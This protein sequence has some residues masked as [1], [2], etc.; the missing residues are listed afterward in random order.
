MRLASL[1][2]ML[3]LF[4]VDVA[5]FRREPTADWRLW[6]WSG[7]LVSSVLRY[8]PD[9]ARELLAAA[10]VLL[11]IVAIGKLMLERSRPLIRES[12]LDS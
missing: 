4:A 1:I 3:V 7:M 2:V 10:S 11:M 6:F 8:A 5:R 9:T 12:K